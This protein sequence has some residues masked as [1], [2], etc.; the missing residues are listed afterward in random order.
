MLKYNNFYHPFR[1]S[2]L[3][4]LLVNNLSFSTNLNEFTVDNIDL[5]YQPL[6][7]PAIAVT[8]C[9][10]KL[11]SISVGNWIGFKILRNI[12]KERSIL[13]D[14]TRLLII[15]QTIFPLILT[16]FFELP[17]NLVYPIHELVGEWFCTLGWVLSSVSSK[18]VLYNSVIAAFMRYFFVVH[19]PKV[20]SYGKEKVK[21][22]FLYL[23]VFLPVFSTILMLVAASPGTSFIKKCYGLDHK[24]F[25]LETSTL[26]VLKRKFWASDIN[27]AQAFSVDH[28]ITVGKNICKIVDTTLL[29]I[30]GANL[31]EGIIYYRI[32]A[33]MTR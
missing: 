21:R 15:T 29:F 33:H 16:I 9:F 24:A 4:F 32:F 19:E 5:Y 27:D 28:L 26:N 17:V 2:S 10:L 12:Q 25:L 3:K 11:V 6:E 20:E 13:S 1:N 7:H 8:F 31:T 22:I 14:V 23:S 30:L 18:I